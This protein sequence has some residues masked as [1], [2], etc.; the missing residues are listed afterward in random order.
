MKNTLK[1]SVATALIMSVASVSA[2]AADDGISIF[3][4]VKVNTQLRPRVQYT[5]HSAA[6][7]KAGFTLTNRTNVNLNAGL[8]EVDGLKSTIELNSVNDFYTKDQKAITGNVAV[9]ATVAKVSQANLTYTMGGTTAVAG[10]MTTNLDNQRFIGSVGWKQNFQT[11]DL[12]GVVSRGKALEYTVAY[13]G[14]VNAIG[15][16]GNGTRE[17]YYG[18]GTTSGQTTSVAANA[19]FKVMDELKVTGYAYML[20]SHSDTYGGALSGKVAVA[21]GMKL[22]YRAEYAMQTDATLE[23]STL[24][25]PTND[26]TYMNACLGLNM[27]GLLV[28]L[29]YEVLSGSTGTDNKTAFSTPLATKHK[30]NGWADRFLATP[31][32]GLV[33]TNVMIG[34]KTKEY[35]VAKVIYHTFNSDVGS[36]NY[37]SELDLLYKTKSPFFKD[38]TCIL[39]A[40]MF[41]DGDN[42]MGDTTKVWFMAD[43]KFSI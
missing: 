8:L 20:G 37:G 12:V 23:T 7:G 40:A 29:N 10:R 2:Q 1:I 32:G 17:V 16:A 9:E 11:L 38:V 42:N 35:G 3:N 34:Y 24:G 28:G 41:M 30:F 36:V 19:S 6:T 27:S 43:Y 21:D 26:A 31:T 14:G 13:V 25:T 39:K 18:G 15:D 22:K 33:D 5:D 4:D